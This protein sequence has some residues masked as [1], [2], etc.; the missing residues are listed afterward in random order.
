LAFLDASHCTSISLNHID[1]G[2]ESKLF[3]TNMF[4]NSSLKLHE[5]LSQ[6]FLGRTI[7]SLLEEADTLPKT[8]LNRRG[9]RTF[10]HW[11]NKGWQST[12]DLMLRIA[13]E[14]LAL[15]LGAFGLQR[16]DRVA[17]L[18]YSDVSFCV[19]DLGSLLA[20]YVN[21][22][23]D[24]TQTL[25][26]IIHVLNDAEAKILFVSTTELLNQISTYLHQVPTLQRVVVCQST[27][28][29]AKVQSAP[30]ETHAIPIEALPESCLI[31]S[32][33]HPSHT[34][35]VVTCPGI[36]VWSLNSVQRRG[37]AH[38]TDVSVQNLYASLHPED[39]ATIVYIPDGTGDLQGVMLTHQNLTANALA[40][41]KSLPGLR[42]GPKEV[43]LSFL[44][45]NHVFAR[46]LLYGHIA[47]GH[48][49]YFTNANR[50]L[51]H[52]QEV[53]PTV[54]STVPLL[55]D[56]VYSK[57]QEAAHKPARFSMQNWI[58]QWG[59]GIAQRY[60]VGCKPQGWDRLLLKLADP[61]VFARWRSVFGGRIRYLLSGGAALKADVVNAFAAAKIPIFQGYGL[62]QTSSVVCYNRGILNRAGTVGMPLPGAEIR[63]ALDQ[64]ILVRGPYNTPGYFNN[65]DATRKLIDSEGWLHTGDL[66]EY[67]AE[68][69]LKIKGLKKD[70]FKLA[71][72]KYIAPDPIEQRLRQ[73]PLISQAV[74]VGSDRKVCGALIFPHW[75]VVRHHAQQQG[76]VLSVEELIHHPWTQALFQVAVDGANCHLPYWAKIKPFRL[77][78]TSLTVANGLLT[79]E[80]KLARSAI[81][82]HFAREIEGLYGETKIPPK[83]MTPPP[84]IPPSLSGESCPAFAQSL[85]PRLTT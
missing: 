65:P 6:V 19:A 43:V 51:K 60:Q 18:M 27:P 12:S 76:L 52:L 29:Q 1:G 38:R 83:S 21:V 57:L 77:M 78:P 80:G 30:P 49:I 75:S 10:H 48:Q 4:W 9:S 79:A 72:G 35:Q 3:F 41:F 84:A 25:E 50:V 54:L 5:S 2:E 47:Y 17:L 20:G 13:V 58:L 85:N 64:E 15:G 7:P 26:H 45:L 63:L 81:G 46:S 71:T 37:E 56:K 14:D 62:T 22:P 59:L 8:F 55:L 24:L 67:T 74:V 11:T 39:L 33:V 40:A 44:P 42:K 23:I 66:G 68:G 36:E 69:F 32:P 73:S 70:I 34:E 82:E 53:N 31:L 16:G 61:L 28:V